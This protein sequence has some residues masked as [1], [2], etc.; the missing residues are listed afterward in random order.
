[1]PRLIP[2][3]PLERIG[4]PGEQAVA[5][6]LLKQLDAECLVYH[7]YP[8]LRPD[9]DLVGRPLRPGEADFVVLDPMRG[10]LV[11]EVKGK[12][13]YDHERRLWFYDRGRGLDEMRDPFVQANNNL[14]KIREIILE[15]S[16]PAGATFPCVHGY[17]VVFADREVVGPPPPGA[18]Q[19]VVLG[20][21][22]LPTLGQH[23][24]QAFARWGGGRIQR[25]DATT[26]RRLKEGLSRPFRLVQI[27][28]SQVKAQ[29]EVLERLTDAQ[30][31]LLSGL[32]SNPR[33]RVPGVAGSGKTLLALARA[34]QFALKDQQTLFICFNN[35]L[36]DWHSRRV[37]DELRARLEIFSFWGLVLHFI[38]KRQ[39]SFR[40]PDDRDAWEA[41]FDEHG[42]NLF[43][44][45]LNRV[46]KRYDAVVVDE[47]QDFK[48]EWW[49]R[50]ELLNARKDKGPLYVFYD[51]DQIL[52]SGA[53]EVFLP[54]LPV[55]YD[56][57]YNCRNTRAIVDRCSR[58][59]GKE[60]LC[61][62][63]TPPGDPTV[64]ECVPDRE[65]RRQRCLAQVKHWLDG[66]LTPRQIAILS[67]WRWEKSCLAGLDT[68]AGRPLTPD[69]VVWQDNGGILVA[70]VRAFKGLEAEALLL[71]D[72]IA[73][74]E[75]TLTRADV[76]VACSR[77]KH[78]LAVLTAEPLALL[79]A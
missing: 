77:G 37:P 11:I 29:E 25:I 49:E 34:R 78:L 16:F 5:R 18:D 53:G 13:V 41:F 61:P 55:S 50:I 19:A 71:T 75:R 39:S 42:M 51:P 64:V 47:A 67:P 59:L 35:K 74:D 30:E 21:S 70:T 1:M 36:A 28:S 2:D 56:L 33:V 10:M 14:F 69:I 38:K 4:N 46:K 57:D 60:L 31:R 12:A 68:I 72:L 8:W 76:Y 40:V 58:V 52:F 23:I 26:F 17:L 63:E 6:A 20:Q 15:H 66:G 9:R 22:A 62:P 73:P 45:A 65:Q 48:P 27:L 24:R 43:D 32:R 54:D 7:S 3:Q 79:G 44:Q